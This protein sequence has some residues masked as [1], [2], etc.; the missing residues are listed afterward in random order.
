[1]GSIRLPLLRQVPRLVVL[2]ILQYI[3]VL[4]PLLLW[5]IARAWHVLASAR[6]SRPAALAAPWFAAAGPALL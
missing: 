1:M 3:V 2:Y 5:C 6:C 4:L